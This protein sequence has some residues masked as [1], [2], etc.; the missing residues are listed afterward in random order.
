MF[1]AKYAK[2]WG[3]E[4]FLP[5]GRREALNPRRYRVVSKHIGSIQRKCQPINVS[6]RRLFGLCGEF[7]VK[8][9]KR[10]PVVSGFDEKKTVNDI[11][12]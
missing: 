1:L 11:D 10:K 5:P 6:L 4:L 8:S 2:G 12:C 7:F 3:L 9:K